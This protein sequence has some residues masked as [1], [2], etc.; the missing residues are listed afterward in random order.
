MWRFSQGG[1]G[2]MGGMMLMGLFW[3]IIFI[4]IVYLVIKVLSNKTG[5]SI[6]EETPLDILQKEFAKGNITE[7]E[8]LSRKKYIE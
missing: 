2:S 1:M 5:S 6:R 7:E 4:V 8:Y 3:L